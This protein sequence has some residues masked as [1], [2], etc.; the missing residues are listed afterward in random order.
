MNKN[1]FLFVAFLLFFASH[2]QS[3]K[4]QLGTNDVKEIQV[5]KTKTP[6]N[7]SQP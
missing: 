2:A 4:K 5:S 6:S 3:P 7:N 1:Y